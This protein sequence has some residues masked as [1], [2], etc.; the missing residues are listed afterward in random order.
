[1]VGSLTRRRMRPLW[2]WTAVL[3]LGAVVA[4]VLMA[5]GARATALENASTDARLA[6]QTELATLLEP[7]DLIAPVV[8]E[9]AM[10]LRTA[11][12]SQITSKGPIDDVR[13]YSSL[14]RILYADD[15]AIVGTRPSYLRNATFEVA[16]GEPMTQ[17]RGDVLQTLVP[18][19]LSPG[20]TVVVAEMSQAAGSVVSSATTPWYLAAGACALSMIG[21]IA[22]VVASSRPKVPAPVP[23]QVFPSMAPAPAPSRGRDHPQQPVPADRQVVQDAERSRRSAESR[24]DAAEQNLKGIQKQLAEALETN[25][26]LEAR[27]VAAQSTTHTSDSES[28]ALRQRLGETTERLNRAE[29]DAKA[30]RERLALRQQELEE[31]QSQLASARASADAVEDL[32][33]R[34]EASEARGGEL[35]ELRAR[36]ESAESRADEMAGEMARM[37][38]DL[39]YT[40]GQFHMSKLSEALRDIEQERNDDQADDPLEHPVIIRGN[41]GP[42]GKVR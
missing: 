25:R 23:V 16:S 19:W 41:G 7:R 11:I 35:E 3:M 9:R 2:G 5:S 21:A 38:A 32:K 28:A 22:L 39:E 15:P 36:L 17:V 6:A 27:L 18:I 14:G 26:A 31:S 4:C 13:I 10:E 37:E 42:G 12:E 24:A 34:L 29:M 1:M 30:L 33:R 20:G 8:G 40:A